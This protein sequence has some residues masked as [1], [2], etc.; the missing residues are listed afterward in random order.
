MLG[1]CGKSPYAPGTMG[2]LLAFLCAFLLA[3]F[4]DAKGFWLLV[5]VSAIIGYYAAHRYEQITKIHDDKK[6]VIDELSGLW[7]CY[8]FF[9]LTFPN[10]LAGFI[11][12]RLFDIVKPWPIGWVDKHMKGGLGVMLDDWLAG[13]MAAL[14]WYMVLR[15]I[16]GH[17]PF[18][19]PAHK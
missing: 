4:I 7:L 9:P 8:A 15:T 13:L 19:A 16:E 17:L 2:S 10:L 6:V 1:P 12:F 11:L 3:P 18:I 14:V 5:L